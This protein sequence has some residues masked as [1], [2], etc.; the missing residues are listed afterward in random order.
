M[1]GCILYC[2]SRSVNQSDDDPEEEEEEAAAAELLPLPPPSKR[3]CMSDLSWPAL[4]ARS[5]AMVAGNCAGSPTSRH[6]RGIRAKATTSSA[7]SLTLFAP[8]AT[9]AGPSYL[10][11]ESDLLAPEYPRKIRIKIWVYAVNL[12]S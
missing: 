4:L 12:S 10:R 6:R 9:G 11:S 3:R 7:S 5:D 1:S 8:K 2:V